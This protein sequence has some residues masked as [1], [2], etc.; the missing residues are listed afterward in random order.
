MTTKIFHSNNRL[1]SHFTYFL[2]STAECGKIIT[3]LKNTK[4]DIN[5]IPVRL[6]KK[7]INY[8]AEPLTYIIYIP[9]TLGASSDQLKIARVT[10]YI[11]KGEHLNIDRSLSK[12]KCQKIFESCLKIRL[13]AFLNK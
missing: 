4:V 6:L 7:I 11:K 13:H 3:N 5:I 9:F 10:P 8:I 12:D 2:F 1:K